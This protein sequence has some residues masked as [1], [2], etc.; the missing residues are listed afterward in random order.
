MRLAGLRRGL[1]ALGMGLV[2]LGC[3]LG[4]AGAA[5]LPDPRAPAA[6]RDL[7]FNPETT[8]Y[9]PDHWEIRGGGFYHCCFAE[10]GHTALGGEIVMPRLITPPSWLYEF[11]IPRIHVGGVADL[12]GGT[13]YGYAGLLFTLNVTDRIFLEPFVGVA[14]SDGVALGDA[15]HNA[16]GC[17]T[18]IHSGGNVGYRFDPHW[19]FMLTL[20]HISNGNICSRNVGVNNYGAKIGYNF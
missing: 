20:D 12:N 5:D 15:K 16:I 9:R 14:V 13:S 2:V 17:T 3:G 1:I 8:L 19:S 6:V 11:F 4:G 7:V 10:S 18:L